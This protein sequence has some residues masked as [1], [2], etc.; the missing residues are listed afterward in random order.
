[1]SVKH[2]F[3]VAKADSLVELARSYYQEDQYATAEGLIEEALAIYRTALGIDDAKAVKCKAILGCTY[4]GQGRYHEAES[5]LKEA[6]AT[7]VDARGKDHLD[8]AYFAHCLGW[9]YTKW[10]R[11]SEAQRNLELAFGIQAKCE[12]KDPRVVIALGEVYERQRKYSR[13]EAFYGEAIVL[14]AKEDEEHPAIKFAQAHISACRWSQRALTRLL[15][16]ASAS[17]E[18]D[19]AGL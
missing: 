13:A 10:A 16:K 8:V 18:S 15:H 4:V 9:L 2:E 7:T 5:L 6:L 1:M 17:D 11:L 3:A 19:V 14:W 12:T